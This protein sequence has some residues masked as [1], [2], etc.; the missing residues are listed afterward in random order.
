MDQSTD[1]IEQPLAAAAATTTSP[2]ASS[3][4]RKKSSRQMS[5]A[6]SSKRSSHGSS[7]FYVQWIPNYKDDGNDSEID[8]TLCEV[9]SKLAID[10][11]RR[12]EVFILVLCAILLARMDPPIGATYVQ[13][14]ITASYIAV[15]FIFR[16][17]S[18]VLYCRS[19]DKV[20]FFFCMVCFI[21]HTIVVFRPLLFFSLSSSPTLTHL[22]LDTC[23]LIWVRFKDRQVFTSVNKNEI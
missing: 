7:I 18:V 11:Y 9:I 23:S 20:P 15:I 13:P 14:N 1:F 19:Q 16:T 3:I 12:N 5:T 10:L 21:T 17:Y 6:S 4:L 8:L 22:H 2:K